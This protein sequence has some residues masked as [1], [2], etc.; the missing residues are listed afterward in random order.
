MLLLHTIQAQTTPV[1][2]QGVLHTMDPLQALQR[3]DSVAPHGTQI[4]I[5]HRIRRIK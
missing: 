2:P 4:T 1:T 5:F 3:D